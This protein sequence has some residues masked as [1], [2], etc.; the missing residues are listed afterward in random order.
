MSDAAHDLLMQ[1]LGLGA[2]ILPIVG[3]GLWLGLASRRRRAGESAD[4]VEPPPP[5]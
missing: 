5:A 2:A 3:L 1:A 4:Y